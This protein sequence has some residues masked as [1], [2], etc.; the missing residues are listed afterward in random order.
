VLVQG[1]LSPFPQE[2]LHVGGA[3]IRADRDCHKFGIITEAL[4][5][6]GREMGREVK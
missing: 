2:V 6:P 3:G 5:T 1:I 4:K